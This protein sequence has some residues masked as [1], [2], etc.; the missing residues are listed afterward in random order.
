M[1]L[2][3]VNLEHLRH[4]RICSAFPRRWFCV[5]GFSLLT[6]CSLAPVYQV[7]VTNLSGDAWKD[8]PWQPAQPG[9]QLSRGSWWQVYQDGMLNDLESKIEEASPNLAAALARYD[10]ATA[11]LNQLNAGLFPSVDAGALATRNRQSDNRPLRGANQPNVYDANTVGISAYYELDIWGKVRNEVAAGKAYAQASAADLEN[12]RLSLH[13]QLADYY[14]RLRGVDQQA[15]LLN[16]TVNAYASALKLT[17]N[18]HEGGVVSGVDVARAETQLSSVRAEIAGL[19]SQRAGYE[20]AIASLI[21]QPA[22][23]FSLP[24]V[25]NK[26]DIPTIPTGIPSTLLQRRPDI[27][28][29]ERRTAAAN[30]AIGVA[31]AAYYPDF[32]INPGLGYQNTGKARLLTAPNS[33]WTLGPGVVFNLFDAGLRDAEVAQ[34]KA[35]LELAGAEYRAVVLTAFQQV[36]DDLAN[37]KY[38]RDGEADQRIAARSAS[39]TLDLVLNRY[40]EGAVN[41]LDVVTAQAAAL[42]AE[43]SALDLHTRQL[44][45]SVDL[46]RALGGGWVQEQEQNSVITSP[47][48]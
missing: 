9:D 43:R 12:V 8:S 35:S 21:G 16:D 13:A 7:P 15:E 6:S 19:A 14:F 26:Y 24:L 28:A 32:S 23:N 44:R 11:Y 5:V 31:R 42:S 38:D 22:M 20:H 37:L 2:L 17:Q 1:N 30:A 34:A 39:R 18:R 27:A 10:Q 29:A 36:E 40:R 4:A 46:V 25:A 41:Y 45:T 48:K 3:R 47:S 33:F